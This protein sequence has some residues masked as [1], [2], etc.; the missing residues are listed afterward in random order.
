MFFLRIRKETDHL[1]TALTE[2]WE[3]TKPLIEIKE[4]SQQQPIL[5]VEAP[6]DM[7]LQLQDGSCLQAHRSILQER[8]P[9]FS[10]LLSSDMLEA[11]NATLDLTEHDAR[12]VKA[13][14]AFLYDGPQG[15]SVPPPGHDD[16]VSNNMQNKADVDWQDLDFIL[17]LLD[18]ADKYMQH[19][20]KKML[21]TVLTTQHYC[22]NDDV[23]KLF[24]IS[25]KHNLQSLMYVCLERIKANLW[26]L[27]TQE[28]FCRDSQQICWCA[29]DLMQT[30]LEMI[31]PNLSDTQRLQDV[32]DA[33]RKRDAQIKQEEQIALALALAN[34]IY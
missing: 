21:D 29:L 13:Y 26:M 27:K 25:H 3:E 33:S 7:V 15:V 1:E 2:V 9:F 11:T 4:D 22:R 32:I 14:L 30:R 34:Q 28:R 12:V 31:I 17:Q 19:D 5:K 10:V 18:V 23:L 6:T 16:D 24:E 20:L 8:S